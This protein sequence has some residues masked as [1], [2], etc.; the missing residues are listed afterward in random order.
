MKRCIC[1]A[2]SAISAPKTRTWFLLDLTMP[3]SGKEFRRAQLDRSDGCECS[4]RGDVGRGEPRGTR[5]RTGAV[6]TL[7]K[8]IDIDVLLDVVKRYRLEILPLTPD[9]L[10]SEHRPECGGGSRQRSH[11]PFFDHKHKQ[12][13]AIPPIPTVETASVTRLNVPRAPWLSVNAPGQR[14]HVAISNEVYRPHFN[15]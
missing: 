3:V 8:P 5:A 4:G 13:A 6:A 11:W 15:M 7:A 9:E 1:C 2:A 14:G 12:C 10:Q